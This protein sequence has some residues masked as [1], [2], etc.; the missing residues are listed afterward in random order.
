M[1]PSGRRTRPD[2]PLP[3]MSQT[4]LDPRADIGAIDFSTKVSCKEGKTIAV[5]RRM[6]WQAPGAPSGEGHCSVAVS[7]PAKSWYLPEGC[8]DFGF[9]C[10]LLIQNPGSTAA[11]CK[12]TYMIEGEG[13]RSFDKTI[14][15]FS[16]SSYSMFQDIGAKNAS[17]KVDAD[18]PVIPERSMYRYDRRE[19][20]DSIGTTAPAKS[21]YLA[22]G[23][24]SW[25]FTT[26]ILVQNPNAAE[27]TVRLTY[28]T[29]AGP[30]QQAPFK[31]PAQSRKTVRVNDA[32]PGKDF[33]TQVDGDI[34][35]IAE[36]A[37]YWGGGTALGEACHDS[38][39]LAEPHS[40]FYLPDGETQGGY[41]TYTLIGNPNAAAADV[42]ISYLLPG[43]KHVVSFTA[44]IPASSR[45]TFNMADKV[46]SG[47]AAVMVETLTA[48]KPVLV[49]RSMYWNSRGAGTNTIG[50]Y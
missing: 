32:M 14:A 28:M 2:I 48:G 17:I 49:E 11:K 19:G 20:H 43:G 13:P 41:E 30:V 26:Y 44:T 8:S 10:W 34:P 25:G 50:C 22:E 36:R 46:P 35:I 5:D 24:T 4:A 37:M 12:V 16:R 42:K 33:S 31:M 40:T 6:L 9:E 38:I 47:R 21:Y 15:P 7:A 45:A 3:P 1:T 27:A 29:G 18:V 39:G 23:T